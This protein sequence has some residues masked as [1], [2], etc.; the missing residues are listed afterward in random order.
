MHYYY[1]NKSSRKRNLS[2]FGNN[3]EANWI[4]NFSLAPILVYSLLF[5][6]SNKITKWSKN[7]PIAKLNNNYLNFIASHD[8]IGMRPI[9]GILSTNTQRK[10]LI[11]LKKN[12]GEF[13][14]R[15][16]QGVKKKYTK[17]IS[18][19]L[20]LLNALTLINLVFLVLK[21]TWQHIL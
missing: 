3:D 5:E 8:G 7:F 19:C 17:Q 12:G 21:D 18:L 11:R 20:M 14:Y 1:R 10:F 6:D 16:V 13:S 15:K 4:Y 9:E 2:Y